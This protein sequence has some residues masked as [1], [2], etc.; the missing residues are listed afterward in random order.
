MDDVLA[1]IAGSALVIALSVSGSM[2]D[3]LNLGLAVTH[4]L[5]ALLPA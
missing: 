1:A 2:G 5:G 4:W 3:A